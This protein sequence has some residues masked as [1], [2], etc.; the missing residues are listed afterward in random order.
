LE[1]GNRNGYGGKIENKGQGILKKTVRK[2][3]DFLN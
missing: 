3:K 1:R 2:K